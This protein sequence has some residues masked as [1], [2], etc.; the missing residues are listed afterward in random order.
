[1]KKIVFAFVSTALCLM[2]AMTSVFAEEA[3][4]TNK[5]T[6]DELETRIREENLSSKAFEENINSIETVDYTNMYYSLKK[7]MN[8]LSTA[9]EFL[10]LTG[11]IEKVNSLAQSAT[12]LR[13]TYEDIRDGKLQRD[14]KNAVSQLRDAQNQMVLAGQSLYIN[15]LTMERSLE[16]GERGVE[17]LERALTEL[18]L[19]EKYGQ[20]S[21]KTIEDVEKNKADAESGLKTLRSTIA[22]CKAQ[23]QV[24]VGVAPTG[25]LEL[26]EL[27]GITGEELSDIDYETDLVKAK[28]NSSSLSSAKNTLDKA[29][30]SR[31]EAENDFVGGNILG[32]QRDSARHQYE[33]EKLN[34]ES[35]ISSFEYSFGELYRSLQNSKQLW[36]NK[37]NNVAYQERQFEIAKKQ[38]EL[39]RISK[40]EFMN[41]EDA[42]ENVKSEAEGA[43]SDFFT[44]L[45]KYNNAVKYGIVS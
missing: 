18:R 24:L 37:L 34:Y 5:I 45:N 22:S 28:E 14:S 25:E 15:I 21:R 40:F 36:E 42:L 43:E 19:R 20:V 41:E 1:M 23:L 13:S 4:P 33:A 8:Q 12:A 9:Q 35:A 17:A 31:D 10:F 30:E 38:Y 2:A 6:W 16:D 26:E 11:Q 3:I 7:Q 39:G 32:Y 44:A 29:E 27:P